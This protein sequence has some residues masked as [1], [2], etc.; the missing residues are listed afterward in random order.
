VADAFPDDVRVVDAATHEDLLDAARE[1]LATRGVGVGSAGLSRALAEVL[2]APAG[3]PAPRQVPAP[4]DGVVVVVGTSHPVTAGQVEALVQDGTRVVSVGP[5]SPS[6]VDAVRAALDADRRVVLTGVLPD[7]VQPDSPEA[8]DLARGLGEAV[9]EV[10]A[11][12]PGAGLVLTGGATALAVATALGATEL[13]VVAEA[14]A[15]LARGELHLPD[16]RVP[17]VTKSGGF[18]GRDALRRAVDAL[19]DRP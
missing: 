12:V 8:A 10:T 17:V 18:G 4:P 11:A 5:G 7:G 6:P 2:P 1:V 15:G 3:V 14:G 13:R 16:H 19:E 9:A